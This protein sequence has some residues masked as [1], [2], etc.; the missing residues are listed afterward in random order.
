[1]AFE[2][3]EAEARLDRFRFSALS[4]DFIFECDTDRTFFSAF[5]KLEY[6]SGFS[7]LAWRLMQRINPF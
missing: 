2:T 3:R 5:S 7:L 1:V 4:L 6:S